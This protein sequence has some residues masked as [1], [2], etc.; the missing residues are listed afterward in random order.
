MITTISIITLLYCFWRIPS[1]IKDMTRA[2]RLKELTELRNEPH[3]YM[4]G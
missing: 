4:E 2:D 1:W 3:L